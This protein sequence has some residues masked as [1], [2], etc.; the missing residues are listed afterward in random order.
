MR[1]SCVRL[2]EKLCI[3]LCIKTILYT[4]FYYILMKLRKTCTYTQTFEPLTPGLV[5][6]NFLLNQSVNNYLSTISTQPITKTTNL[7]LNKLII[8]K[9]GSL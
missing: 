9:S 3:N 6:I 1:K 2:S 7:K 4:R 8:Y 5:H